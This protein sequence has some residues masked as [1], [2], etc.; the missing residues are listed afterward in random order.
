[1]SE[2][3]P[4]APPALDPDWPLHALIV[5][6]SFNEEESLPAVLDALG[7]LVPPSSIVVVDDGSTDDTSAVAVRRGVRLIRMPFNIGVGGALRA[8]LLL[9]RRLDI[10]IVVQCDG[11][12]QHPPDA[13]PRLVAALATAD[14]V[15]GARFAGEGEYVVRGPRRWAMR[16]LAAVMSRLHGRRLT[17][18]TSG[19][20]A[21]GPRAV[22]VLSRQLP[23]EYLG[24]TIEALVIARE[25][26]LQVVQ[27]PV[28][29]LPRQGGVVSQGPAR[30]AFDL[31]RAVLMVGLS[32]IRLAG[33]ERRGA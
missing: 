11:D 32:L 13:I 22:D 8:G 24:D 4:S 21:F 16:L 7:T 1:M 15:I 33:S 31:A 19:F 23:P 5:I 17:D 9:A 20:R 27:V 2:S 25:H 28:A 18:V 12:G 26:R 10:P 14:I 3:G 29:M 6:P 30:A